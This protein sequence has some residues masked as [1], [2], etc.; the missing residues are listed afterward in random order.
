MNRICEKCGSV[1][2]GRWGT[3]GVIGYSLIVGVLGYVVFDTF[4]SDIFAKLAIVI[5]VGV[6]LW[7]PLFLISAKEERERRLADSEEGR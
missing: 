4:Y 1:D 5:I 2:F 3:L 7:L 6:I